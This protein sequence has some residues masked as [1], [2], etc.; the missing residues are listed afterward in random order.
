MLRSGRRGGRVAVSGQP[1]CLPL[2]TGRKGF[3]AGPGCSVGIL[4][5]IIYFWSIYAA[6]NQAKDSVPPETRGR[7][8]RR[9][10]RL[11][12]PDAQPWCRPKSSPRREPQALVIGHRKKVL[13]AAG[14]R[15]SVAQPRGRRRF[16][17]FV[18]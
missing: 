16:V 2:G 10:W 17:G 7:R 18:G 13:G 9:V 4:M 14:S 5:G 11:P 8:R 15:G 6:S 3:A 1:Q 12:S